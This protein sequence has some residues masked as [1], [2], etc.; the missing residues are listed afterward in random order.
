MPKKIQDTQARIKIIL[1]LPPGSVSP[2]HIAFLQ[3][4]AE[5]FEPIKRTEE[6]S[7][8][9]CDQLGTQIRVLNYLMKASSVPQE[10]IAFLLKIEAL[11]TPDF[12]SK[13]D[14]AKLCRQ[15]ANADIHSPHTY[16]L[17]QSKIKPQLMLCS[18]MLLYMGTS[19]KLASLWRSIGDKKEVE[20]HNLKAVRFFERYQGVRDLSIQSK[21]FFPEDGLPS[22]EMVNKACHRFIHASLELSHDY[23]EAGNYDLV[24][25]HMEKA[26]AIYCSTPGILAPTGESNADEQRFLQGYF[27]Y[28]SQVYL[29]TQQYQKAKD[30]YQQFL[31]FI[32]EKPDYLSDDETRDYYNRSVSQ[33]IA[34]IRYMKSDAE[35]FFQSLAALRSIIEFDPLQVAHMDSIIIVMHALYD[36]DPDKERLLTDCQ[37]R[38]DIIIKDTPE[39]DRPQ[40]LWRAYLQHNNTLAI[41]GGPREKEQAINNLEQF[42]HFYESNAGKFFPVDYLNALHTVVILLYEAGE[43]ETISE[44]A[45]GTILKYA[46]QGISLYEEVKATTTEDLIKEGIVIYAQLLLTCCS[47]ETD[48]AQR[49]YYYQLLLEGTVG[50]R[51]YYRAL[52]SLAIHLYSEGKGDEAYACYQEIIHG[53]SV[54]VGIRLTTQARIALFHLSKTAESLG[55]L[56]DIIRWGLKVVPSDAYRDVANCLLDHYITQAYADVEKYYKQSGSPQEQAAQR[57]RLAKEQCYC[58][59]IAK[60]DLLKDKVSLLN[61]LHERLRSLLTKDTSDL[62]RPSVMSIPTEPTVTK[63]EPISLRIVMP[64]ELHGLLTE[65]HEACR[66]AKRQRDM[67]EL[68]R[69]DSKNQEFIKNCRQLQSFLSLIEEDIPYLQGSERIVNELKAFAERCIKDISQLLHENRLRLIRH[70]EALSPQEETEARSLP[71]PPSSVVLCPRPHRDTKSIV[72]TVWW[73]HMDE[74]P[75]H[76]PCYEAKDFIHYARIYKMVFAI[77]QLLTTEMDDVCRKKLATFRASLVRSVMAP[78]HHPLLVEKMNLF[79]NIIVDRYNPETFTRVYNSHEKDVVGYLVACKEAW[80]SFTVSEEEF[81][82]ELKKLYEKLYINIALIKNNKVDAAAKTDII[83]TL[84][85]LI[86]WIDQC[87]FNTN[88]QGPI[89]ISLH[90]IRNRLA[91]IG[92]TNQKG[93]RVARLNDAETLKIADDVQSLL[94][95]H[96]ELRPKKLDPSSFAFFRSAP[97][98]GDLQDTAVGVSLSCGGGGGGGGR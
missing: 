46:R 27:F 71:A 53:P 12:F 97:V 30:S 95:M 29:K 72:E 10:E 28:L 34:I 74:A 67:L 26:A 50:T 9:L 61:Q 14:I 84:Q 76:I 96:Y 66:S 44:K 25:H 7:E 65:A 78:F 92:D 63:F 89:T 94:E 35:S 31:M 3:K 36:E 62:E 79:F 1:G 13:D 37:T 16:G 87:E 52:F 70:E 20:A 41:L 45:K 40:T 55:Y 57:A 21:L 98:R 80:E 33:L 19:R 24:I 51:E 85:L 56:E 32:K 8:A 6:I 38:L 64:K 83:S 17:F 60:T 47:L 68:D 69:E 4:E 93:R 42:I 18:T 90:A 5:S 15:I 88:P 73:Q 75:L 59:K 23:D 82:T 81:I 48:R 58:N 43:R 86:I 54:I 91:H 77:N 2:Q 11:L 49:K 39:K 22:Q